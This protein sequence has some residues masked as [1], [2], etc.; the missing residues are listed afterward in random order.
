[1]AGNFHGV[2]IFVIFVVDSQS[3][4]LP[5]MKTNDY[6]YV[7]AQALSGHG[8][9]HGQLAGHDR[10]SYNMASVKYKLTRMAQ[11]SLY[12]PWYVLNN[13]PTPLDRYSIWIGRVSVL[14][15][16][17]QLFTDTSLPYIIVNMITLY[18]RVD[19]K[20]LHSLVNSEGTAASSISIYKHMTE[21]PYHM[22]MRVQI[23]D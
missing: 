23:N 15:M 11:M 16:T 14:V 12:F 17:W 8:Q 5:P 7:Y 19:R 6:P 20:P 4:K 2:L 13:H 1:M 21:G 3:Q 18:T 10:R 9:P 22:R